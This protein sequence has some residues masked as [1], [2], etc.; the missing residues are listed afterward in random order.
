[1]MVTGKDNQ[2]AGH[3]KPLIMYC[4]FE[5]RYRMYLPMMHN[6]KDVD[7]EYGKPITPTREQMGYA[8]ET[9]GNDYFL[10]NDTKD[11]LWYYAL[12]YEENSVW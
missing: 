1:M 11:H 7:S 9:S 8:M 5:G 10:S 2:P 6:Y 12:D 4:D 3:P